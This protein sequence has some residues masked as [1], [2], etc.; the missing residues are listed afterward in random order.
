MKRVLLNM[1]Q[2]KDWERVCNIISDGIYIT[3]ANGLTL[4]VNEAYE[5]ITGI[6]RAELIGKRMEQIVEEG[7]LSTSITQRV[8]V[9]QEP[10]TDEQIVKSGKKVVLQGNP[11]FLDSE[12][13][14]VVTFVRDITS[15]NKMQEE[16]GQSQMIIEQY[17]KKIRELGVSNKFVAESKE[18]KAVIDLAKKVANVDST[19]LILGESGTGKEVVAKEIHE[20]SHRAKNIFLKINCGAIPETLLEAEL[21]GYESGAFTGAKKT[22]HIG[23]FELASKGTVFLDEIGDM[24]L[25]LQVKLLRVLQEKTVTRIG[26]SK[27]IKI[28][29]RVITATNCD[30]IDMVLKGTFRKDLYY[31]L[32]V[33]EIKVPPLRNRKEE[34]PY[35]VEYF[36]AKINKKYGFKKKIGSKVIKKFLEYD[37]PGNVRELENMI[38]RILVTSDEN[39]IEETTFSLM[40]LKT[41]N[42]KSENGNINIT[43]LKA[44][45]EETERKLIIAAAQKY[46]TTYE[47]A[48]ALGISQ[49]S[50]SRKM[51]KYILNRK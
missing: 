30:L 51:K 2:P 12:I 27:D 3:N 8:I 43:S 36:V 15:I 32:N 48:D 16:L 39:M 34:I 17:K 46:K 50:A 26:G 29:T 19:V 21:F 4:Y 33:V 18:F 42:I 38:E 24:P 47:I 22:G 13:I 7:L 10:I 31:R 14:M 1:N 35:F 44:A 40:Q 20:S 49:P 11:V 9:K 37:W 25:R 6:A 23:I 41:E 5:E 45:C 28:D